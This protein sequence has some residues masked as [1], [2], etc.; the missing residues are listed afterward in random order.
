M[1][2]IHIV[3]CDQLTVSVAAISC[4]QPKKFGCGIAVSRE[5]FLDLHNDRNYGQILVTLRLQPLTLAYP[6]K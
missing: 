3:T 2:L 4:W 5:T 1:M 6:L